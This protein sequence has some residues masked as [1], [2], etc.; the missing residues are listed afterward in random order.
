MKAVALGGGH[1]TAAVL[2][3]LCQLSDDVGGVVS[4]ADDGGSSGELRE[5]FGIPAVGDLRRCLSATG[6]QSLTLTKV[7]EHRFGEEHHPLGNL[8]L[9]AATI[10]EG[11]LEAAV[12]RVS[13]MTGSSVELLPATCERVDLVAETSTGV[14]SG[15]VNVHGRGD[16]MKVSLSPITAKASLRVVEMLRAA[17]LIV[18]GPGSFFTSVLATVVTPGVAEAISASHAQVVFLVNLRPEI[19]EAVGLGLQQQLFLLQ[20][21]G[22]NPDDVLCDEHLDVS[23]VT[24]ATPVVNALADPTGVNHD[25]EKV[26][27]ALRALMAN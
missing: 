10:E 2:Q 4:V 20:N 11:T 5:R 27:R 23:D 9:A 25:P 3:A 7:L 12:D 19:P 6:D 8:L 13:Q 26:A 16:V 14:V 22:I 17:D 1:G 18:V 15:Q 21:H 24:L